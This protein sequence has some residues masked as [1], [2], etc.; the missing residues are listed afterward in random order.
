MDCLRQEQKVVPDDR[1]RWLEMDGKLDGMRPG[2]ES[3]TNFEIGV[4]LP[5]VEREE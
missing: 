4:Y 3:D 2:K 5:I 1:Q